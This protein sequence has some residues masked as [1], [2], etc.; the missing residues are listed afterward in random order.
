MAD[1]LHVWWDGRRVGRLSREGGGLRFAYA[2]EWLGRAD[3]PALSVSL[4]K[5]EGGFPRRACR[6]FF[7]GLLPDEGQREAVARAL[8]VSPGNDF[9]LLEGL[10]GEVAG[11][12]QLLSSGE[13]PSEAST[14]V[15]PEVLDEAALVEVLETLPLRPL[16]ASRPLLA[17]RVP[18]RMSLAGAQSKLPVLLAGD[19]IALPAVGQATTH[20][21]KPSASAFPGVSDNEAFSMRLA[22]AVGLD[23]AA[24]E[25]R[26]VA[27]RRFLL[28]TRYDRSVA[29]DGTVRRVHQED[30]CQALGI[31]PERKYASEGGPTFRSGF[32]LL[33]RGSARPAVE[34]LKLLDAAIFNL[35]LGNAD[36]HGKNFS[37]LHDERGPRLAPLY[38][39]VATVVYEDLSPKL[40]M[41]MGRRATLE[42]IDTKAWGR[43]AVEGGL[44]LPLVRR[45][46]GEVA[47]RVRGE[48]SNVAAALDEEGCDPRLLATL[49]TTVGARAERC[50]LSID[51]SGPRRPRRTTRP[52]P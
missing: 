1:E 41:K 24:V 52:S 28:V 44:G 46:V 51:G 31:P 14:E 12:L 32:E 23:V 4:P 15:L 6:P 20:I 37:L 34:V 8:G 27:G 22:A 38:D 39:L 33:R 5:R 47:D 19:A 25:P 42:E 11:A 7:A 43:F 26:A 50:A 29:A 45:R 30:F 17:G 35:I 21:L 16:L 49:S 2:P 36:A 13:L 48:A 10:G 3:A 40:A 18:L 9:A